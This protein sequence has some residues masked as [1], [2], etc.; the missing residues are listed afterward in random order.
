M[1]PMREISRL[2]T[3][4]TAVDVRDIN[5]VIHEIPPAN[6][7]GGTSHAYIEGLTVSPEPRHDPP[8]L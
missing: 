1:N 8:R 5:C 4:H 3:E 6:Y 7:F 2:V